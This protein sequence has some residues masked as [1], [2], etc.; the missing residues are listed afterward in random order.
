MVTD[1]VKKIKRIIAEK[2][3]HEIDE[4]DEG[5]YFEDDLNLGE[6]ELVDILSEIEDIFHV[7]LLDRKDEIETVGDLI[8]MVYEQVE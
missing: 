2:T 3:G 7:E 6:M 1:Y 8:D 4:I 5:M